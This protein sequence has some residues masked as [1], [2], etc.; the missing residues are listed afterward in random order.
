VLRDWSSG[1]AK[2]LIQIT[3]VQTCAWTKRSRSV[4]FGIGNLSWRPPVTSRWSEQRGLPDR[5]GDILRIAHANAEASHGRSGQAHASEREILRVAQAI[6]F[7][8]LRRSDPRWFGQFH[9][10]L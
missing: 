7:R 3:K 1:A 9:I 2:R 10:S 4:G 8:R 5:G 6:V